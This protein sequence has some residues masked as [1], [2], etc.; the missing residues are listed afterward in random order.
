MSRIRLAFAACALAATVS[1]CQN[2]G[3]VTGADRIASPERA[4]YNGGMAG[5][6]GA[7]TATSDTTATARG[8][9][10]AGSGY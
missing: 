9:G 10:M 7:S 4:S 3:S 8:I 2:G 6:G 1:A 5:S